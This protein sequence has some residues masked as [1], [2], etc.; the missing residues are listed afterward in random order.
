MGYNSANTDNPLLNKGQTDAAG[1]EAF[2]KEFYANPV[3]SSDELLIAWFRS[4]PNAIAA[5]KAKDWRRFA[6]IYN[7]SL[8]CG[9][10][11]HQYDIK[12]AQYY[13]AALKC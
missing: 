8:C 10:N 9:P 3:A 7:G 12:L 11:T 1:A 4:K 6:T 2:V 5:A 13:Q